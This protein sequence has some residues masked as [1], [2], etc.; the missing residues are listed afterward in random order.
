MNK[1]TKGTGAAALLAVM[2][3]GTAAWI[4]KSKYAIEVPPEL[5][6]AWQGGLTILFAFFIHDNA[7]GE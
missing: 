3:V 7:P 1:A 2:A 4:L 5:V 6:V